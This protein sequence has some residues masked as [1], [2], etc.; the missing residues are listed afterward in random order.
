MQA[1]PENTCCRETRLLNFFNEP[2]GLFPCA[3]PCL[4]VPCP[5]RAEKV[6]LASLSGFLA[7]RR[8]FFSMLLRS[9]GGMHADQMAFAKEMMA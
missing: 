8:A 6:R 3:A 1:S 7:I 5:D 2:A 4:E 9:R